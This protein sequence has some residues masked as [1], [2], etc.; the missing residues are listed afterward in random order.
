MQKCPGTELLGHRSMNSWRD[1]SMTT[2]GHEIAH[3][4]SARRHQRV[5]RE[6]VSE[7]ESSVKHHTERRTFEGEVGWQH[8]NLWTTNERQHWRERSKRAVLH[9]CYTGQHNDERAGCHARKQSTKSK[10]M[11][12]TAM[13]AKTEDWLERDV[14]R[15]VEKRWR[16]EGEGGEI[17]NGIGNNSSSFHRKHTNEKHATRRKKTTQ[18][19][20]GSGEKDKQ[21]VAT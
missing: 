14:S 13:E 16:G 19:V 6:Q 4:V 1:N 21:D 2:R 11:W 15:C 20:E 9:M 8:E 5:E 12:T 17:S 3:H 18:G 10:Y 7:S